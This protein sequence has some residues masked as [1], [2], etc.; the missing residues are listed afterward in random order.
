[1]SAIGLPLAIAIGAEH[2]R[3]FLAGAHAM[4][5]H[6]LSQPPAHNLPLRLG[7]LDVWYRN[8]HGF[9]RELAHLIS[10]FICAG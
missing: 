4:D 2:F 1:M 6:F 7:L 8:F 3:Q 5:Q 9:A 10:G